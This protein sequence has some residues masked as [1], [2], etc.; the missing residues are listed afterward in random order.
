MSQ[1]S[2]PPLP[3]VLTYRKSV[4]QLL[5]LLHVLE[6]DVDVVVRAKIA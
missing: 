4:D 1:P 6:C 3:S 2:N 5:S